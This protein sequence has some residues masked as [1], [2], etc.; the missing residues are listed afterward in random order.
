MFLDTRTAAEQRGYDSSR[1]PNGHSLSLIAF[2]AS[3]RRAF[4]LK[5]SVAVLLASFEPLYL[6]LLFRR[7]RASFLRLCSDR[8]RD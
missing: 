8:S 3:V 6:C 7:A 2:F 1:W 4:C 5:G